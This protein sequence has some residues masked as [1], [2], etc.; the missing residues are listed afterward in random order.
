MNPMDIE[1]LDGDAT[2]DRFDEI[3]AVYAESFPRYD[4]GDYRTRMRRQLAAPGFEAVTARH[5]GALAGFVYGLPLSARTSWWEG[6]DPAPPA[7]FTQETGRRTFAVIDLAVRPAHRRRGLGR[8]LLE[9]LLAGRPEERAVLATA[10]HE[11]QT[12]A[13]YRRWGWRPVGRAP[14]AAAATQPWFDLYLIALRS[15]PSSSR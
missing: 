6:L 3:Q 13:M 9:E 11:H 4:L 1:H 8:R 10:P 12:Q 14:G 2:R 5:E 7:G 15:A